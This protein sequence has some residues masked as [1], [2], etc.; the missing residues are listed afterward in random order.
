MLNA[1]E[2]YDNINTFAD[3][4]SLIGRQE[5]LFLDFKQ[6][7]TTDGNL[8]DDDKDNFRVALSGFAHQEGGVIIWG[9]ECKKDREGIDRASALKP[10]AYPEKFITSLHSYFHATTEPLLDCVV[11]KPVSSGNTEG[12]V[13]QGFVV[14]YIPKSYKPHRL[15]KALKNAIFYKRYGD[16]FLPVITTE[17]IRSLFLRQYSPELQPLISIESLSH[18]DLTVR[19][20]VKNIGTASAKSLAVLIDFSPQVGVAYYDGGGNNRWDAWAHE[21]NGNGSH[22]FLLRSGFVLHPKQEL[23]AFVASG[24]FSGNSPR[25]SKLNYI[26][27]AEAMEPHEGSINL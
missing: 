15:L 17:E 23:K 26:I 20:S 10:I 19:F 8:N 5:D 6:S 16:Q 21:I 9:I 14:T 12:V 13:D 24:N 7:A 18:N 11:H 22:Y 2:I 27:Y 1:Q 4:K 25:P 3:I